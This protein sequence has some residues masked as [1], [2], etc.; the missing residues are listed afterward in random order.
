MFFARLLDKIRSENPGFK[1]G[2][3]L[4]IASPILSWIGVPIL[5]VIAIK[6]RNTTAG[7]LACLTYIATW[8]LTFIGLFLTGKKGVKIIYSCLKNQKDG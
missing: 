3:I 1:L 2:L 8:G 6:N 7:F 4:I 5:G